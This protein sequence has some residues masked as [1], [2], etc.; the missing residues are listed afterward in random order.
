MSG[1]IPSDIGNLTA[2]VFL[3]LPRNYLSGTIPTSLSL[4]KHIRYL[5]FRSNYLTMGTTATVST[6]IFPLSLLVNGSIF[7]GD[8]CLRFE[9]IDYIVTPTHCRPT[10]SPTKI[11]SK[12]G[13]SAQNKSVSQD[14]G[15]IKNNQI[16]SYLGFLAFL[17]I[18]IVILIFFVHYERVN[19]VR[20]SLD[21]QGRES[22]R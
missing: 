19:K 2:V 10:L 15:I 7:L 14:I 1:S 13:P 6:S 5:D 21:S 18:F 8:N 11:S 22:M 17:A 4:M 3:S 9:Y 12:V 16:S 20:C